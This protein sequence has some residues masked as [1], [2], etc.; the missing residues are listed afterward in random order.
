MVKA[1]SAEQKNE[2]VQEAALK[3]EN[4]FRAISCPN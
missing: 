3:V 2:K 1:M 4:F